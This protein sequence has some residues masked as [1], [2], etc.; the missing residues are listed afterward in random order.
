ME[1]VIYRP[2]SSSEVVLVELLDGVR[3]PSS[4]EFKLVVR[5]LANQGIRWMII[6][7]SRPQSMDSMGVGVLLMAHKLC[8]EMGGQVFLLRPSR[9]VVMLLEAMNM[10]QFF[11]ICVDEESAL[12]TLRHFGVEISVVK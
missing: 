3:G 7:V 1:P 6:D 12:H 11:Q 10:D 8:D 2:L 9:E 4:E 5:H